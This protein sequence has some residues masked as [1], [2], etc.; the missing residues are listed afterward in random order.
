[1]IPAVITGRKQRLKTEQSL[2]I[3]II[4]SCRPIARSIQSPSPIELAL[5]MRPE[6][7]T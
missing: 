2:S 1:M 6:D 3:P 5:S 7:K 4:L